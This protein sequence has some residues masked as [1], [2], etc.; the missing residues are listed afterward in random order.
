M[1]GGAKSLSLQ[2]QLFVVRVGCVEVEWGCDNYQEAIFVL[3]N[4]VSYQLTK[5][6]LMC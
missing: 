4:E 6:G 5:T 2:T 1:G 3:H